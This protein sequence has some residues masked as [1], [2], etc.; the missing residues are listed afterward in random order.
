MNHNKY[1]YFLD[2][3]RCYAVLSV[4]FFHF[5]IISN[6]PYFKYLYDCLPGVPLF[7]TISGFLITKILTEKKK[8]LTNKIILRSFYARRVL[9][10]FPIYYITLIL[11]LIFKYNSYINQFFYDFFYVSNLK[12]GY[13]GGYQN[14][15]APH[16]WSLSVEEQ[17]YLFWPFIIL[18]FKNKKILIVSSILFL[19][20]IISLVISGHISQYYLFFVDR[21]FGNFSFIGLGCLLAY[22]YTNTNVIQLFK[23]YLLLISWLLISIFIIG[24]YIFKDNIYFTFFFSF[25]LIAFL[26]LFSIKI[27]GV[28][29][30]KYNPLNFFIFI[31]KISYGI[32][33]Y[34]IFIPD[35]LYF[36]NL[37]LPIYNNINLFNILVLI[38]SIF[39]ATFSWYTI[40]KYFLNLK[41]KFNY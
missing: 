15:I 23:K 37:K 22:L 33:I 24:F 32:Y 17:F 20:G 34:H 5:P 36:L 11:L 25:F 7:F 4:V 9:R 40:E 35:I 31:G 38:S 18:F 10:I 14:T 29:F 16:F 8:K 2:F 21:T 19:G 27:N 30:A 28:N 26:I 41:S 39:I 13:D 1:F 12:I 6:N 3:L